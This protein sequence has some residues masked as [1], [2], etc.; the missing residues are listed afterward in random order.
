VK[1]AIV[2]TGILIGVMCSLWMFTMGFTGWY[3]NPSH[4]GA[5]FLVVLIEVAGLIWGLRQTAAQGR[6]YSGQVVA[7][8]LMSIVAGAI[9]VGASLVFTTVAFPEFFDETRSAYRW[10]LEQQGKAESEIASEMAAWSATQTP[11]WGAVNGFFGTFVTGV[12]VSAVVAV[13]VRAKPAV[14]A[15]A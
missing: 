10:A 13:W 1:S 12:V 8:T 14:H 3:K 7:G 6:T 9:I 15:T 11:L 4:A 5:F 2:P